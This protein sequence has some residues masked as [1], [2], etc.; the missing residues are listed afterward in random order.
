[1]DGTVGSEVGLQLARS[2]LGNCTGL[3]RAELW[4]GLVMHGGSN[5]QPTAGECCRSCREYE[6]SLDVL[7]GAQ[8]T[9]WVWHPTRH[10]CW[11]K[12]QPRADLEQSARRLLAAPES[13]RKNAWT[14]GIVVGAKPCAT[15]TPPERYNGCVTKRLCNTSR[16]CGSPAIDGYA[17]VDSE[18]LEVSPTA[19]QYAALLASGSALVG[20]HEEG[21]D[22]DGLGVR[23]GIGHTKST[24][25]QCEA[26]CR[27]H[28]P[29]P[30]DK[31]RQGP[32]SRLPCNVWTWCAQP[33]CFEPDAHT[34]SFGDCWLKFSELPE[35]PEV[36]MRTPM[37]RT[38][39]QRHRK[40]MAAGFPWVSGVLLPEGVE[41]TNGTWGPRAY[42]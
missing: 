28:R 36:N 42:W 30:A 37:L 18:C 6:P 1:M 26:A 10:E 11:L 22:L 32:F 7:D 4:G 21:L 9:S 16:A 20:H 38:Y 29:T 15:C 40:E 17:H 24:W 5:T 3:V 14:S 35:S 33:K 25:E 2:P 19:R 12:H 31:P 8:C 34:H 23:W 39:M 13:E 41:L 27:A